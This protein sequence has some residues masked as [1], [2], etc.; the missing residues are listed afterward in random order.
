[1]VSHALR[2]QGGQLEAWLQH[3]LQGLVEHLLVA[4][5]QFWFLRLRVAATRQGQ[6]GFDGVGVAL[7]AALHLQQRHKAARLVHRVVDLPLGLGVHQPVAIPAVVGGLAYLAG[8]LVYLAH[9]APERVVAVGGFTLHLS[10]RV[11]LC[12][13]PELVQAVVVQGGDAAI[14]MAG[15]NPVAPV[16]VPVVGGEFIIC[17]LAPADAVVPPAFHVLFGRAV[18]AG[19][20]LQQVKPWVVQVL[21]DLGDPV[22]AG[23]RGGVAARVLAV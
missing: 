16:V 13:L 8:L 4:V 15:F 11:D 21:L 14:A 10:L 20:W 5:L 2:Q 3:F 12:E 22:G 1:M 17:A 9:P 19:L 6:Q 23:A 18:R 7:L